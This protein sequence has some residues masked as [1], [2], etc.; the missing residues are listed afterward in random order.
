MREHPIPQ[1]ITGY[2]FHIIGELTLRQFA[3]LAIGIL[4]AGLLYK[5]GFPNL[6][7]IPFMI[8]F[9]FGGILMAFFPIEERPLEHWIFAFIKSIYNP[10]KFYWQKKSNVPEVFKYT[11]QKVTQTEPEIDIS[12]MRQKRIREYINSIDEST[13]DDWDKNQ[14]T[15]INNILETFSTLEVKKDKVKP[16][17]EKPKLHVDVRNLQAEESLGVD[18]YDPN[19]KISKKIDSNDISVIFDNNL[20]DEDISSESN[21]SESSESNPDFNSVITVTEDTTPKPRHKQDKQNETK[22]KPKEI[23]IKEKQNL[24]I[25]K[26]HQKKVQKQKLRQQMGKLSNEENVFVSSQQN[27]QNISQAKKVNPAKHNQELPFP[28]KPDQ[29]NLIIGMALSQTDTVLENTIIEIKN[30]QGNIVRAIKTNALG[31]FYTTS[32]LENGIY[33]IEAEKQGFTFSPKKIELIGNI[34]EPIEIRSNE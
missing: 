4:V 6:I 10:T 7:R 28:N 12:P 29:P 9:G 20:S 27:I 23:K 26:K 32:P 19:Q 1:D 30:A 25:E 11:S 31:Q 17:Q 33:I 34:V 2:K 3:E 24:S 21:N 8:L 5:S 13:A 16:K 14:Q 22:I 15:K 18:D